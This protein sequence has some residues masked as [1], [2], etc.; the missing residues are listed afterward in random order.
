MTFSTYQKDDSGIYIPIKSKNIP[1]SYSDGDEV[2]ERIYK[3][4]RDAKDV[5]LASDE[6]QRSI[7]DWPSEYHFTPL[8]ANLLSFL[9][10]AK[11]S[12]ILEVGSG[13]GAI[14]RQLGENG[15]E[16]VALEGSYRRAQITRSRC[17]DLGNVNVICDSF[18][19]LSIADRFDLIT[20]IGVLE[21]SPMFFEDS[22]P[23]E[24]A[25]ARVNE[26]LGDE[27]VAVF[28]I[29]NQLGLKYFNGCAEDHTGQLFDGLN[30]AYESTQTITFGKQE[31]TR[32]LMKS[33]FD[34]L[35]FIYPFP[36]YKL[37]R[38]LVR[39]K[40][41]QD[42]DFPIGHIIGQFG[43]RDYFQ[44]QER[45]FMENRVWPL[46]EKNGLIPDLA[47]SFLVLAFKG[48]NRINELSD[49]WTMRSFCGARKKKFLTVNRFYKKNGS[50]LVEKK[51][52]FESLSS[53]E[54][55]EEKSGVVHIT[56]VS[57]FIR[58]LP[59]NHNLPFNL[60]TDDPVTEYIEYLKPWIQYLHT[61]ADQTPDREKAKLPGEFLDCRPDNFII[62]PDKKLNYFDKEW[63]THD[64]L[65]ID[66][67][68]FRGILHDLIN[69][70]YWYRKADLFGRATVKQW[71]NELFNR[72]DHRHIS[73]SM[74]HFI[75]L[76]IAI[77]CEITS[78]SADKLREV[79]L[80][81]LSNTSEGLFSIEEL[82]KSGELLKIMNQMKNEL[83]AVTQMIHD[84]WNGWSWRIGRMVTYLPR[85]L[86]GIVR[87]LLSH[88]RN[89]V[90][91]NS[92]EDNQVQYKAW[93]EKYVSISDEE[94]VTIKQKIKQLSV[95][96][97]I[98]IIMPV[99]N[100]PD[101]WLVNAIDSVRNQLY[102]NW[103]LCI[104]DDA[105]TDG[106]VKERLDEYMSK[107][108]RIKVVLRPE[109]GHISLASN[110][111]LEIATGEYVALMDH[112]DELTEDALYF[113]V[114]EI[115]QHPEAAFFYSDEDKIDETGN[116]STPYFKPDWNP[117]LFLSHNYICHLAVIRRSLI[118]Q[119]SGFRIGLEGAQDWDLFLRLSEHVSSSQIRHVPRILYH[120]RMIPG[121]TSLGIEG[122]SY[123]VNAGEK[124]LEDAIRRRK[125]KASVF[126][127]PQMNV[128][129]VEHHLIQ[130][131]KV[132]L[133]ILTRDKVDLLRKCVESIISKTSYQN[134]EII[135]VDNGSVKE[136]TI[137]YLKQLSEADPRVLVY[138]DDGEFNFPA[139][140]NRGVEKATGEMIGLINNDIAVISP[141]WLK[142][143]VSHAVRQEVGAV[144]ARLLYPDNT[145]QH[146][147]VITGIQGVAGHAFKGLKKSNPGR[148]GRAMLI[149]NYSAVTA[150]CI[151]FRRKVYDEVGGM[152]DKNLAIAFN[153]IDFCLRI[154]EKGYLIVYS[155]Y[156]E[157]Y[158][159]E[160]ASR[161]YEDTPEKQERFAKEI[162]YMKEQWGETLQNDPYY[163]PNLTLEKEDF[164]LACPPR[165][166]ARL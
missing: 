86:M 57:D 45:F 66:F 35:E 140:N 98:S 13:C 145:I 54:E 70:R 100:T 106:H 126:F 134:Y 27:G 154:R 104:A 9:H 152:D 51:K 114:H 19:R 58:G 31:L 128:F 161:G 39:E 61:A 165:V 63:A 166:K 6:L 15:N 144:G 53:T 91:F 34:N 23:V 7:Q 30:N 24:K 96:P 117:D 77:Q 88:V 158:H 121:S 78:D 135:I 153:D 16:I 59:Y 84:I 12:K 108:L 44:N 75:E 83:L 136:E 65:S 60:F 95:K 38:V 32:L 103:E 22:N 5:S 40:A 111:A 129:R 150:A 43:A 159:Y 10:L 46:I 28:A 14:T 116:L 8:R 102:G 73:D 18:E 17:R 67:V 157:L 163:N 147:G 42:T 81:L 48:E 132:S 82:L 11:F 93:A 141:E 143:M 138:R 97:L 47:N 137:T 156:A 69:N 79:I 89:H 26:L 80:G 25:L 87:K 85:K 99:Y 148:N 142:E 76:E 64:P 107:D 149:Q 33:G 113:M 4:V 49:S 162:D 127:S 74:N 115:N 20:M 21:Y 36:D 62:G 41:L 90:L 105:S 123:A 101:N 112:D 56:G 55:S 125:L 120:W 68:I 124:A 37:P 139:L 133:I 130:E 71:M 122:K 94:R 52:S 109:N 110:S 155:P 118:K 119:L 92:I 50:L 151:L 164:S 2:E 146:A 160:S 131:P 72:L 1:F 29:E 3:T